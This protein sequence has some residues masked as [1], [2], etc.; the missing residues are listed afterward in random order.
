MAREF[1]FGDNPLGS[2][3]DGVIVGGEDRE[4]E[5]GIIPGIEEIYYGPGTTVSTFVYPSATIAS[6]SRFIA[7]ATAT[8]PIT[9]STGHQR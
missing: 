2:V 8:T 3:I 4:F 9:T 7:I 5:S 6:W 1:I